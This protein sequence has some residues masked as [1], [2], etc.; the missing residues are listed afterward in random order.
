MSPLHQ[1]FAG[2]GVTRLLAS[3]CLLGSTGQ[4][5][6]AVSLSG[7]WVH[8]SYS[9]G[10]GKLAT[11]KGNGRRLKANNGAYAG[12]FGYGHGYDGYPLQWTQGLCSSSGARV[13]TTPGA[14][15]ATWFIKDPTRV[16]TSVTDADALG[17]DVETTKPSTERRHLSHC[18]CLTRDPRVCF[19]GSE[20]PIP[21][22]ANR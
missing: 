22:Y 17:C 16:F 11:G 21:S 1:C 15:S 4:G 5:T 13:K 20:P 8:R 10:S 18:P 6:A 9:S 14:R 12:G 2:Q 19:L 3:G 7:L